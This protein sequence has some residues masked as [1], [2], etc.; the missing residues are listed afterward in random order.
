MISSF[1]LFGTLVAGMDVARRDGD[2]D[3]HL[4]I[5]ENIAKVKPQ[6]IVVS[7][8]YD[9][10]K[11]ER[12]LR[13]VAKLP[14]RLYVTEDGKATG[15]IWAEL[16]R[17]GISVRSHLGDD[18]VTDE[19]SARRADIPAE[20]TAIARP[21]EWER[22]L[23]ESG[24]AALASA[25][26]AARLT[27]W[28]AELR[29]LQLFQIESNFPFLFAASLWFRQKMLSEGFECLL[30]SS[31]DCFLWQRLTEKIFGP[32]LKAVYWLTSRLTRYR[33]SVTYLEYC[34][35]LFGPRTLVTD[36]C[37]FGNSLHAF[38]EKIRLP[39]AACL[40]VGY[41]PC[42]LPSAITGWLDESANLARHPMVIDVVGGEPVY[43]RDGIDWERVPEINAMH[44]AF[45]VALGFLRGELRPEGN[46]GD[47]LRM[48][49]ENLN[50]HLDEL[51][52][53]TAFRRAEAEASA[54]LL[55]GIPGVVM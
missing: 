23:A 34:E 25:V 33:P 32:E 47:W 46:A 42:Q 28:S 38:A 2:Q 24:L 43:H 49:F 5:A 18:P 51:R 55:E 26:R 3:E 29:G 35:R 9:A 36:A 1:D 20:L 48:T 7:D 39:M 6:D 8:Y 30:M 41:P 4:P 14:N 31:R 50:A 22:R 21:N 15:K 11:A 54:K 44:D 17:H 37:G 40:L 19:A 27:T 52:P 45:S 13:E 10:A 12:I 53:L 16:A